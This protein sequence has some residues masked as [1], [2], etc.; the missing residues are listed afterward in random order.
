MTWVLDNSTTKLA[1]RLVLIAI[2]NHANA[3]GTTSYPN[4]TRIAREANVKLSTARQAIRD[5]EVGGH[6]DVQPG[7]GRDTDGK[8]RHNQYTIVMDQAAIDRRATDRNPPESNP[9]ESRG[10]ESSALE[11]GVNPPESGVN[12]PESCDPR[13]FIEPSLTVPEPSARGETL[14]EAFDEFW[15]Q[16]PKRNDRKVGKREAETKWRKIRPSDLEAIMCGLRHY[17]I[18]CDRGETLAKDPHRWLAGRYWEDYQE[19]PTQHAVA[20]GVGARN[21]STP[22]ERS[23]AA[24]EQAMREDGVQ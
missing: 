3:D 22:H 18:A 11:S 8:Y 23:K 1:A 19:P 12:P 5:L 24:L 17:R 4:V 10:L 7:G 14:T 21:G 6:I 2:A 13:L 16:Y 9:P 15:S 20:A